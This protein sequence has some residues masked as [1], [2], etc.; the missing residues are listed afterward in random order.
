[1]HYLQKPDWILPMG[2]TRSA[3]GPT[4]GEVVLLCSDSLCFMIIASFVLKV[5]ETRAKV[6]HS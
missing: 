5:A 4:H 1:M 2:N 6:V 3:N